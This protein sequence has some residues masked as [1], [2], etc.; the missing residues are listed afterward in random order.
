MMG[1]Y[2]VVEEGASLD[3]ADHIISTMAGPNH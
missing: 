3:P 1:Q 2:L